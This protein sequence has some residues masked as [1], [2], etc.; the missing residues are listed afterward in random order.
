VL[1]NLRIEGKELFKKPR[2]EK[3][4]PGKKPQSLQSSVSGILPLFEHIHPITDSK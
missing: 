4:N 2:K 1:I 3:E